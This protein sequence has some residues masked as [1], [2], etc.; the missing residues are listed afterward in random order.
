MPAVPTQLNWLRPLAM[1]GSFGI[2]LGLLFWMQAVLIPIALAILLTFLLSPL[3]I[4]LQRRGFN[5]VLVVVLV[6]LLAFALLAGLGW[7]IAHQ[8]TSLVDS[9]PQYEQNLSKKIAALQVDK[10]GFIDKLQAIVVRTTRLVEKKESATAIAPEMQPDPLPV[11][12]IQ[13]SPFQLSS[14]WSVL[15]P[16]LEPFAAF[17]LAIVLV[18]FM[19]LKREDLRDRMISLVGHG[20]LTLT[21]KALD[22]AGERISRYLLM[23]LLINGTYG[24]AVAIGLYFIGV[25]YALLWGFFATVFRYIPYLGPWLAALLPI[26]LSLLVYEGWTEPFMVIGLFGA[27]E[28]LSNMI[29]EPWLYGRGIG[30]S[31]TATL[32]M[33]AFWT[34]LWGPIGLVLATPLTVCLVVLGKYVPFLKFFDTLLGDQPPFEAHI[35]YY[36][37]LLA[38]DHDE[39]LDI[40]EEYLKDHSLEETYDRLILPALLYAERDIDNAH[41]NE[42]DQRFVLKATREIVEELP[43]LQ[44]QIKAK[45]Q[46]ADETSEAPADSAS[47]IVILGCPARDETDGVALLMLKEVLDSNRYEVT[48]TAAMLAAEVVQLVEDTK[49]AILCIAAPPPGGQAHTRLLCLRLR[50]RFPDLKIVVGRWGLDQD[51][52]NKRQQ[53]LSAGA[54]QFGTTLQE[55]RNQIETLAQLVAAPRPQAAAPQTDSDKVAAST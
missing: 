46:S 47:K 25:P 15:G 36:Q 30:V 11:K 53:L 31:A 5:R 29:M 13:E 55:T 17:G 7:L 3:V 10:G 49:P 35:G 8:V 9:F 52:E 54:D 48:V 34:W 6:V 2:I 37:R 43:T 24:L 27:L 42:E 28:L 1:L 41:L 22:E 33:I 23:Q 16:I 21:T 40:A 14:I 39:A 44:A 4:L 20:H 12:I 18:M 45:S 51:L 32:V 19:L 38:K 26:G 50:S